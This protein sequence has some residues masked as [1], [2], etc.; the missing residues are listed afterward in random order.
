MFQRSFAKF[1]SN[2]RFRN[3]HVK[4]DIDIIAKD[5][6][7]PKVRFKLP[8]W[9]KWDDHMNAHLFHLSYLRTRNSRPWNPHPEIQKMLMESQAAWKFFCDNLQEPYLTRCKSAVEAGR[10][11]KHYA[12]LPLYP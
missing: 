1:F 7:S 6:V 2:L 12:D 8:N 5:F 11:E 9:A 3:T 10:N 4:G